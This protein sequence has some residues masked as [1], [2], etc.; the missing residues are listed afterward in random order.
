MSPIQDRNR[1]VPETIRLAEQH[2]D[3]AFMGSS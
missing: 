2:L 1:G 3:E